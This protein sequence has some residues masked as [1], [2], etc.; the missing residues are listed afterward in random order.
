MREAEKPG[1]G[2]FSRTG[3]KYNYVGRTYY[4]SQ[5]ESSQIQRTG[6]DFNRYPFSSSKS[7]NIGQWDHNIALL[8]AATSLVNDLIN[9]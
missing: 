4:Q 7:L 5:L 6:Q 9:K 1:R 3:S 8:H 2:V